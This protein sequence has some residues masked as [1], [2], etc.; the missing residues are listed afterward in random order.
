MSTRRRKAVAKGETPPGRGE[1]TTATAADANRG[2]GGEPSGRARPM[3]LDLGQVM[4]LLRMSRSAIYVGI[5]HGAFPAPILV[6]RRSVRW[7]ADEI[8]AWVKSRP[9]GGSS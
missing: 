7:I 4:H 2:L 8:Y 9:R 6:G 3:L 5:G 1:V